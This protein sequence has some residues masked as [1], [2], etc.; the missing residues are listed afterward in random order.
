VPPQ[1]A[2]Q[3]LPK[4]LTLLGELLQKQ[5]Q[6]VTSGKLKTMP[7]RY[8]AVMAE[9]QRRGLVEQSDEVTEAQLIKRLPYRQQQEIV[10]REALALRE[11]NAQ[12]MLE[13]QA[14]LRKARGV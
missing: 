6:L 2:K 11:Q 1:A 3:L 7:D 9:L 14:V 8:K 13:A 5:R 4:Q 10:A 12:Q